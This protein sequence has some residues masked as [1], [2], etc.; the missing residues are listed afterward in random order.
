MVK[1]NIKSL[2]I[3][4]HPGYIFVDISCI[5]DKEKLIFIHLI[6]KQIINGSAVRIQHHSIENLSLG[7][8]GHII[9]ENMINVMLGVFSCNIYFSHMRYIENT[10]MLTYGIMFIND[11]CILNRHIK[12][13]E[14]LHQST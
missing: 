2:C 4:A 5:N 11:G 13:A 9:S 14:R 7:S 1:G 12:A 8:I 10:T 3:L 6:N